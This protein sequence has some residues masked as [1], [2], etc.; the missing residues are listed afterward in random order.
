[1]ALDLKRKTCLVAVNEFQI[2]VQAAFNVSYAEDL[3]HGFQHPAAYWHTIIVFGIHVLLACQNSVTVVFNKQHNLP[4][5]LEIKFM[6][7]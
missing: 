7:T 2:K 3:W 6:R 1:M 5:M 4:K